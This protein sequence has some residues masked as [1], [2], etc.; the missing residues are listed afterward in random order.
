ME[1]INREVGKFIRFV[2]HIENHHQS[3]MIEESRVILIFIHVNCST[4]LS[5]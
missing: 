5:S 2:I 1:K 4:F 3:E